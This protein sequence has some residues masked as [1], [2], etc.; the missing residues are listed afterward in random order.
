[1]REFQRVEGR[2][3]TFVEIAAQM[4]IVG[5]WAVEQHMRELVRKGVV[6]ELEKGTSRRYIAV[7]QR[8]GGVV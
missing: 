6:C 8:K 3:A 5:R 4:G 2:P 1:M 7:V